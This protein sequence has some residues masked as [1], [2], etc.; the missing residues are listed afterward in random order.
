MLDFVIMVAG[1]HLLETLRDLV[2]TK[3]KLSSFN[4]TSFSSRISVAH[5]NS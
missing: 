5:H 1:I 3:K 4:L 2:A